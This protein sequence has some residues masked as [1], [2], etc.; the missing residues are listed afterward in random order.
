MKTNHHF[1]FQSACGVKQK[2][3]LCFR[4]QPKKSLT[5]SD[6]LARGY[7]QYTGRQHVIGY[8]AESE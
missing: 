8:F 1:R 3:A 7:I 2:K 4:D 5:N 6:V